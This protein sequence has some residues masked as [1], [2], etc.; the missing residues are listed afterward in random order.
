MKRNLEI[1]TN[2]MNSDMTIIILY[3][4]TALRHKAKVTSGGIGQARIAWRERL[5]SIYGTMTSRGIVSSFPKLKWSVTIAAEHFNK[6]RVF[7]DGMNLN[8][9]SRQPCTADSDI[10]HKMTMLMAYILLIVAKL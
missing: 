7:R 5:L 4:L 6:V 3:A 2:E 10:R 9:A 8:A 1:S